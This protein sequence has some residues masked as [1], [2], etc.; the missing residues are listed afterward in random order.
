MNLK[1]F[2]FV[3]TL[4]GTVAGAGALCG[5]SAHTY[6]HLDYF[7]IAHR[8]GIVDSRKAE[9]SLPALQAAVNRRYDMVEVDLR[10]TKD[11]ELI[12]QHDPDFKKYYNVNRRVT[13]MTWDEISKLRSD[14]GGSRVLRF[15]EVLQYCSGKIQLMIDNKIAGNDTVLFQRVVDLM[16]KYG[17]RSQALMIGT[18]ASTLFFT[19]KIKLSCT[20]QQLEEN[21]LKPGYD[22]AHYY[23]FGADL[24][25][26]DVEWAKQNNIMAVGVV[27]EWRYKRSKAT[28]KEIAQ[29]VQRLKDTGLKCFQIDSMFGHFFMKAGKPLPTSSKEKRSPY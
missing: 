11:S 7:L 17:L 10:L 28:E 27:N 25:K 22:P 5:Q 4:S 18:E 14:R 13:D 26:D 3:V 12:I 15:E 9:N 21:M 6:Q 29:D 20:R 24:T 23:L 8:G 19:G 1:V 2:L 16:G